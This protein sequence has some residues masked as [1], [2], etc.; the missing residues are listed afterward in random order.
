VTGSL[1]RERARRLLLLALV[2]SFVIH[3]VGGS[4]WWSIVRELRHKFP[5]ERD[6]ASNTQR[7]EIQKLLPTPT[8]VPTPRPTPVPTPTPPPPVIGRRPAPQ[9]APHHRAVVR[10]AAPA[11]AAQ[12]VHAPT[13][14]PVIARHVE[15]AR[16]HAPGHRAPS[17]L[18][19]QEIAALDQRYSQAINQYQHDVAQ[20]PP[21]ASPA[22]LQTM[23]RYDPILDGTPDQV[24]SGDGWCDPLAEP[25]RKGGYNYYY[26]SCRITYSDG[27]VETVAIPWQYRFLPRN[28]PFMYRDGHTHKF[29]VQGPPDGFVLP[30]PF[31]LSRAVCSFYKE[32]CE[33]VI[34]R[35]KAN[36]TVDTYGRP[37]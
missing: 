22:G 1:A 6:I 15:L 20:G 27:F 3:L 28:D 35:E 29:P 19:P 5:S 14:P 13:A 17:S 2:L 11:A 4:V 31:P 21:T 9:G 30:D 18:T 34:A 32:K 8:P 26:L 16:P 37:P 12:P 36:G 10:P 23:K 25:T 24:L 33:A 7:I